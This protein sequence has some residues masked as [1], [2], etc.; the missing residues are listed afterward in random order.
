MDHTFTTSLRRACRAGV[1]L[2]LAALV[3]YVWRHHA[4]KAYS[5]PLHWLKFARDFSHQ[6]SAS[7]WP[8]GYPLFLAGALELVG[9]LWIFLSNLPVLLLLCWLVGWCARQ[10]FPKDDPRARLAG[11]LAVCFLIATNHELLVY[12]TNPY[13]D[14]LSYV[15][16]LCSVLSFFRYSKG[17]GT[18]FRLGWM[19]LSGGCAGLAY[20]VRETSL[21]VV[22]FLGLA[23]ILA[24]R[25][26][27]SRPFWTP[28]LCFSLGLFLGA[29]P[30]LIQCQMAT[31]N[32]FKPV[33][34]DKDGRLIP[35]MYVTQ[36]AVLLPVALKTY[37]AKYTL[38]GC[39]ATIAGAVWMIR[40]R[41][42]I[43]WML[44]AAPGAAYFVFY[45]FYYT[46]VPRY[47]F[48]ADL[49][50]APMAAIGAVWLLSRIS[51]VFR[52][53]RPYAAWFVLAAPLSVAVLL[54]SIPTAEGK[55][56][57]IADA[58]RF[59]EDLLAHVA[60]ES[61]VLCDRNL[62]ELIEWFSSSESFPA[63]ALV[64]E[65]PPSDSGFATESI[66][67]RIDA[68]KSVYVAKIINSKPSH[69]N[70]HA[71]AIGHDLLPVWTFQTSDYHL[72]GILGRSRIELYRVVPAAKKRVS[73]TLPAPGPRISG[74]CVSGRQI[75]TDEQRT[76][77]RLS[78]NGQLLDD[79][80]E[81]GLNVYPVPPGLDGASPWEI[82]LESDT[83]VPSSLFAK[84]INNSEITAY[85]LG[86]DS[87][88]EDN[89]LLGPGFA[90]TVCTTRSYR[91]MEKS[92]VLHLPFFRSSDHWL[93]VSVV[94]RMSARIRRADP[95]RIQMR[96]TGGLEKIR[97]TSYDHHDAVISCVMEPSDAGLE[98]LDLHLDVQPPASSSTEPGV[99]N[100]EVNRVILTPIPRSNQYKE[101]L[102]TTAAA[103]FNAAGL[104]P[105]EIN[106]AGEPVAWSGETCA[107]DIW[108]VPSGNPVSVRFTGYDHRPQNLPS[109]E[110]RCTWMG[111]EIPLQ[112]KLGD[113]KQFT[114]DV[115][116]P[117]A[118]V[119]E[120]PNRMEFKMT[121]WSPKAV[122]QGPDD[123]KLGLQ[124]RSLEV[125]PASGSN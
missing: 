50:F 108:L 34:S 22:P 23:G 47:F 42:W 45:C 60:P 9:P 71:A 125:M 27:R 31:G 43:T 80:V 102:A 63:E 97:Q 58:E 37:L 109:A 111:R 18:G 124:W 53:V 123:R 46:Y 48:S 79:R 86:L 5:D 62:C 10:A 56:F 105:F 115:E 70:V 44:L 92:G 101:R 36:A 100:L 7:K 2:V 78:I 11:M 39:L 20:C 76:F 40:R 49:F 81:N 41:S 57:R 88:P 107:F 85:D 65:A 19:L 110:P 25:Q 67:R 104:F 75:W 51:A 17:D 30:F 66:R 91:G 14:P 24:V 121:P 16:L 122:K 117:P 55:L 73:L 59:S 74:L 77:A 82:T 29:L 83:P 87:E 15:L 3:A 99:N 72:S 8:F 52:Q 120:G 12:M 32:A 4:V 116:V 21:L 98:W 118:L 84:L 68:G 103:P 33:Q 26:D 6:F 112:F 119:T 54:A 35:G 95:A 28:V 38:A 106:G 94:H 1:C 89:R 61:T 96:L 13:R 113:D 93:H 114:I 64:P 69:L 90:G